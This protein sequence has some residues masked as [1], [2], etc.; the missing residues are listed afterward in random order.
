MDLGRGD[1]G[2]RGI[3]FL[4]T[5]SDVTHPGLFGES[6]GD[7][8]VDFSGEKCRNCSGGYGPEGGGCWCMQSKIRVQKCPCASVIAGHYCTCHPALDICHCADRVPVWPL[9]TATT[10]QG[11]WTS[12]LWVFSVHLFHRLQQVLSPGLRPRQAC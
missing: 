8:G 1:G 12:R 2:T 3:V 11:M 9:L 6:E 4:F 10:M 5:L 7:C